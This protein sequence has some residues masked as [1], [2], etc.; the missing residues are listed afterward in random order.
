MVSG[1]NKYSFSLNTLSP[2]LASVFPLPILDACL[3]QNVTQRGFSTTLILPQRSCPW[4]S[5]PLI[6]A[7]HTFML[8]W[9]F[10]DGAPFLLR[11]RGRTPARVECKGRAQLFGGEASGRGA[12][13]AQWR[14]ARGCPGTKTEPQGSPPGHPRHKT[15]PSS[16]PPGP[17]SFRHGGGSPAFSNYLPIP[18]APLLGPHFGLRIPQGLDTNKIHTWTPSSGHSACLPARRADGPGAH[19]PSPPPTLLVN[20]SHWV[21]PSIRR[22]GAIIHHRLTFNQLHLHRS[23][24]RREEIPQL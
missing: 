11:A 16:C 19:L 5:Q 23:P 14:G 22:L 1:F 18:V 10:E 2:L 13:T 15:E 12:A 3:C 21:T 9:N 8:G 7:L 6:L 4:P 17:G 20:T 24:P